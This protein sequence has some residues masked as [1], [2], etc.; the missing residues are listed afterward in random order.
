[1]YKILNYSI[2]SFLG[3]LFFV[4]SAQANT[5]PIDAKE[6]LLDVH[7]GTS[8]ILLAS[9]TNYRT[10]LYSSIQSNSTDGH[11]CI[12]SSC[13]ANP[14]ILK[15][16]DT[17][18]GNNGAGSNFHHYLLELNT[19]I[20]WSKLN[21]GNKQFMTLVY[22]DYNLASSS[23]PLA[24]SLP[25]GPLMDNVLTATIASIGSKA[26]SSKMLGLSLALSAVVAYWII[27][28]RVYAI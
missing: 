3:L 25:Q 4:S 10:I 22:V 13:S 18:E 17:E 5:F 27:H 7:S 14:N 28:K 1:M 23:Q 19:D 20:S 12:G 8:G 24:Y 11:I 16:Q 6:I 26:P 9:S 21:S 2:A 15:L